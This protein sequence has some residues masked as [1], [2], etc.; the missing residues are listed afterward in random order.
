METKLIHA[1]TVQETAPGTQQTQYVITV[2][3][4][5]NPTVSSYGNAFLRDKGEQLSP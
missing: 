3:I 5:F 1:Y 2:I 4:N